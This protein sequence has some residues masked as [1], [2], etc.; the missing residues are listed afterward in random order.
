MEYLLRNG[1]KVLVR[2]PKI[3]DAKAL[4]N[5]IITADTETKFLGRKIGEFNLTEKEEEQKIEKILNSNT[6]WFVVEYEGRIIGQCSIGLVRNNERFCHRGEVAFILLKEYWGLGIGGKMM[7]ECIRWAKD[8]NLTQ[9]ELSIVK[10]NERALKMYKDFGFEIV[11][12]I[13]RALYYIDGSY[14]NEY[15]MVKDLLLN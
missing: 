13:P 5:V 3:E 14:A 15:I 4:I 9:I 6:G 12:E 11:G 2:K 10:E 1:K 7:E 8:N